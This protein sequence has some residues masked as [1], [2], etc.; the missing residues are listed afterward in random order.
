MFRASCPVLD[1]AKKFVF[2]DT[3]TNHRHRTRDIF[4]R[5]SQEAPL[6]TQETS[7][8]TRRDES[9]SV[10]VPQRR[11]GERARG[12]DGRRLAF[13]DGGRP[14]P[15]R[16]PRC[17]RGRRTRTGDVSCE[18]EMRTNASPSR[19]FLSQRRRAA[20]TPSSPRRTDFR[21][22]RARA[23]G[24]P[25]LRGARASRLARPEAASRLRHISGRYQ[26]D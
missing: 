5:P 1:F 19:R 3:T 24:G 22:Q 26:R 20:L 14:P 2:G 6:A 18:A 4:G 11:E 12:R 8:S 7:C 16:R 9:R 10:P 21:S 15:P 23:A 25:P 13:L 17:H